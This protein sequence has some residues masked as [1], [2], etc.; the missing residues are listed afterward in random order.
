M[1]IVTTP[2]EPEFWMDGWR[3][4][5]LL[6]ISADPRSLEEPGFWAVQVNFE[7]EVTLARFGS[8]R[9]SEPRSLDFSPV[10]S[11]WE[12]SFTQS[13]F[14]RYVEEIRSLIAQGEVYQVNACRILSAPFSGE[15]AGLFGRLRSGNPA[16][17]AA[18]LNLPGLEIA[19]A[20]P[21]LFLRVDVVGGSRRV[22]S[23]PIKG[24]SASTIF[25]QKDSA[26][27]IMIVDLIRNDLGRICLPGSIEVPRLLGIEQHPGLYH[28]VSDVTGTLR[29][30]TSWAE[31]FSSL[32]PAGSISGAPKS[33][34]LQ[35]IQSHEGIRGPYCGV[36]GY[37]YQ[38][39][40]VLSV[41]IRT[42]WRADDEILKF[43]TGAG[44]TWGS[45][46][47]QEWEET[48]LKAR[49][50]MSIANGEL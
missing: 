23:S 41:A 14:L 47:E 50:L 35:V 1:G 8:V 6:E 15:M 39:T 9:R 17:H 22:L 44:I 16:K 46:P 32:L 38:G 7:G 36:L 20:S 26:E 33:S 19:S 25:A 28:L 2:F 42:F 24:T 49:R 27:N 11:D 30:D 29:E 3:A 31:I 40:A 12:S 13:Q 37:V 43:G 45:D 48:E 4:R 34:A 18:Y 5:D 21:E 10:D